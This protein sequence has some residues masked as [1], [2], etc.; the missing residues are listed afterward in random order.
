M[1]EADRFVKDTRS[2]LAKLLGQAPV[3]H[4]KFEGFEGAGGRFKS[5][6]LA[7]V[8]LSGDAQERATADAAKHLVSVGFNREDLYT[9]IGEGLFGY[10]IKVQLLSRALCDG[11]DPTKPF[12]ES[13]DELRRVLE[14]DEVTALFEHMLSY[15]EERSPLTKA[16]SWEE[17]EG[18]ID[19][20]G[21]GLT[22]PT[23]LNSYDSGS[24]RFMLR[25][26]AFRYAALTRPRSSDISPASDSNG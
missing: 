22:A 10:E 18:L 20:V 2:P 25:E 14:P 21:K 1:S 8:S 17:V 12:A 3:A 4:R 26:L 23:S 7:L 15:Q 16:R 19:A 24:L 11:N 6:S 5:A 9:E 13:A